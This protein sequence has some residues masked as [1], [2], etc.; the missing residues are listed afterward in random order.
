MSSGEINDA[1]FIFSESTLEAN[2]DATA[3]RRALQSSR[4]SGAVLDSR[5]FGSLSCAITKIRGLSDWPD[6]VWTMDA[7]CS[8]YN[9]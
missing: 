3:I 8:R 4:A 7:L 1:A 5:L 9:F 6:E 2:A